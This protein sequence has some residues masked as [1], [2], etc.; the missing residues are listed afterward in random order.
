V[1]SAGQHDDARKL[2]R[3]ND[4]LGVKLVRLREALDTSE[5][6]RQTLEIVLTA[7]LNR[8]GELNDRLE[9]ARA[10]NRQLD[11]ENDR[12]AEMVRLA[13]PANAAMPAK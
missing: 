5:R 1:L 10:Q 2:K 7:R 12:L 4:E 3:E 8:I 11:E 9:R 13:P 6:R